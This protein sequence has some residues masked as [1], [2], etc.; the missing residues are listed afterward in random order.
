MVAAGTRRGRYGRCVPRTVVIEWLLDGDVAVRFQTLRDL[1]RQDDQG[2]QDRIADEGQGAA[3]LAARGEDGHWGAGFYQPKWTSSH[4]TL[5]ELKNMGLSRTNPAAR[6]TVAKILHEEKGPDGGLDPTRRV[7]HSDVCINGMA[8]AYASYFR[9][10]AADLESVVDFLLRQRMPDG[11]Y[12]CRLNRSGAHHSSVHTTLSVIEG[13]T[14]Y[15]HGG[16]RHRV[17]ELVASR[18]AAVEFLLR[19]RLF[20]SERTAQPID[21][22]LTRLHHPARW[23]FD[24]L[25]CLDAFRDAGVGYDERLDDA[26]NILA[27]RRRG[28]GRWSAN[29]TYAGATHVPQPRAGAPNRWIT[30]AAMRVEDTYT[31]QRG[32]TWPGSL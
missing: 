29:K 15:Q 2:L 28:D 26:L 19:H 4:Y 7:G 10:T 17:D 12:N 20:R 23:R 5:L 9:A 6:D 24:I 22:E 14:E 21:P 18:S 30:L 16:Y 8:L 31:R 11:G 3:M 27:S 32:T 1:M 25:R 13:V